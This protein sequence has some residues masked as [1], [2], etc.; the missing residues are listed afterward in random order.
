[1]IPT[2][3]TPWPEGRERVAAVSSFGIG[4]T[5]AHVIVEGDAETA[6]AHE[7]GETPGCL[8]LSASS[9][10]ALALDAARI[11]DHLGL[12]PERLPSVLRHLQAGR[13]ARR[14]R[15]AAPVTDAAS[16]VRWL[17]AVASGEV[18]YGQASP[19]LAPVTAAGR[20]ADDLAEAW[21]AGRT[22][23]WAAGPAPAPWDFP[24]PSFAL[25]A[26]DFARA[27][28][29]VDASG[30]PGAPSAGGPAR[31]PRSRWLH[32]P[33]WVRLRRAVP[34][35]PAAPDDRAPLVVVVAARGLPETAYTPFAQVASRVVRVHPAAAFGREGADVFAADPADP[36]SLRLLL[37]AL[38]ADGQG[39]GPAEVEWV[40]ALPLDVRGPVS[41][42]TLEQARHACLDTTAALAKAVSGRACTLRVWWLSY[43][44]RPVTGPVLRPELALLAGP[45]AVGPQEAALAGHWLDLPDAGLARWAA[46]V[47]AAVAEARRLARD[48]EAPPLPPQLGLRQGFWWQPGTAPVTPPSGSAY[49]GR[50]EPVAPAGADAVHLVLGGTGGIGATVAAWLL[51][52]TEGRV[53]LLSRAPRVPDALTPWADRVGLVTADLATTPVE[54]VAAL[55]AG[56]TSRLDSVVHAAG[57]GFGGLL[58]RRDAKAMREAA[59]VRE[60]GA[61]VVEHLIRAWRP[62]LAVYCSSMSALLGGVG[63]SDYAAG[64]SLLDG[65]AHHRADEAE[66]TTRIGVN[67]DIW[68]DTGMATR[69]PHPDSR[70]QAHLAVGLTAEEGR[71]VF[72]DAV[73]L[74]LPQLLV[75]T[76]DV[77]ESAVFYAP[78]AG[79]HADA[80]AARAGSAIASAGSPAPGHSDQA[81]HAGFAGATATAAT[82]S[83]PSAGGAV[84]T[85][86]AAERAE[87]LARVLQDLLGVDGLDPHDSLYDLGADSLTLLD[88]IARIEEDHGVV[89]DLTSFSHR[90]SLSEILKHIET[91]LSPAEPA[92]TT[93]ATE[94][95]SPVLL[96]IWQKGT[97]S[98]VLCVIHPVGGDIHAYRALVAALGPAPTVCLIA[99]PGLRDAGLPAWSLAERA[100]RYD[101]ALRERF[102]GTGHRLHLAGWSFGAR[103]AMEMAALAE[104]AR[105]PVDGLYLLDPPPPRA[106][107]LVTAYDRSHLEAVFT[108]ELGT[109]ASPSSA[110]HTQAYAERLARC[111][112]GNL[113]SLGEHQ[114]RPLAST[115]TFLWL[116]DRPTPGVPAPGDPRGTAR[117]WDACLPPSAVRRTV[118]TDHYG[119]VAPPHVH[120][121]A[122]TIAATSADPA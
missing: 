37:D 15:A 112:R 105:E 86:G 96:D 28:G 77:A 19:D 89:C 70:H 7:G 33:H 34:A 48:P 6:S 42:G 4:G 107:A 20:T 11:A 27:A 102:G 120:A 106:D 2:R 12:R 116:A 26:Y 111:C 47:A 99:D 50:A 23:E 8:V 18:P 40:H 103:V 121:V 62:E 5:N 71:R 60:N 29:P 93:T 84:G 9:A 114:V 54:E 22:V 90:V 53:L 66:T 80:S 122:A 92:L 3:A 32:Q 31:L 78:A 43:G 95:A 115:P 44:A 10:T 101:A 16:A 69:V 45:V 104:A 119:I 113:S 63:Q 68:R 88:L 14:L 61:L 17:R 87:S 65:F 81:G 79:R 51:E 72:A 38:A 52:H 1:Y 100:R 46:P 97:G 74:R 109:G 91:A 55:V 108:A 75:S 73:S 118:P 21:T 39:E 56:H 85:G 76:T 64:A 58:V 82:G 49:A 59:A 41:P 35:R 110:E 13:V 117:Q 98:A 24:P 25:A 94:A 67:W 36:A 30:E 57:L 83:S